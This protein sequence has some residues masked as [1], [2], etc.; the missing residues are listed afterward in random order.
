MNKSIS[1]TNE[2]RSNIRESFFTSLHWIAQD[3]DGSIYI[4]RLQPRLGKLFS[5]EWLPNDE[6]MAVQWLG[7]TTKTKYNKTYKQACAQLTVDNWWL[8]RYGRL[9]VEDRNTPN[10]LKEQAY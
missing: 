4:F 6:S 2:I 3:I 8:D 9:I 7:N 1:K 10:L 5:D